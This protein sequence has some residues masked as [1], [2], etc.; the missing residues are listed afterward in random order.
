MLYPLYILHC[1]PSSVS[2]FAVRTGPVMHVSLRRLCI[3]SEPRNS[4]KMGGVGEQPEPGRSEHPGVLALV[5]R[6][7]RAKRQTQGTVLYVHTVRCRP[8]ISIHL[9]LPQLVFCLMIYLCS[10]IFYYF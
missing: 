8:H 5:Y 10:N 3:R 7:R 4:Q 6:H 1:T 9:E 2:L